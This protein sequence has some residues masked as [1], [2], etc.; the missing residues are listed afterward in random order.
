MVKED[1]LALLACSL[2]KTSLRLEGQTLIC[3]RFG[4]G[5]CTKDDMILVCFS[6][7]R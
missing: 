4:P 5:F 6:L 7:G 3:T 2:G 1:L